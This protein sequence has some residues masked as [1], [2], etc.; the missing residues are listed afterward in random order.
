MSDYDAKNMLEN[1]EKMSRLRC[2]HRD[3]DV[4]KLLVCGTEI[5]IDDIYLGTG[6]SHLPE[7]LAAEIEA[8]L[9]PVRVKWQAKFKELAIQALTGG[10]EDD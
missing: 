7:A 3:H 10:Q 1:A 9:A 8:A 5:H 4:Y 2:I 6:R